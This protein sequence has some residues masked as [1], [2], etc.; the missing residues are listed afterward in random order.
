MAKRPRRTAKIGNNR[1]TG[2]LA[3]I[4]IVAGP[5]A[6]MALVT[7]RGGTKVYIPAPKSLTDDHWLVR[8]IGREVAEK[9][10]QY[11]FTPNFDHVK[12]RGK[13]F[14]EHKGR[15]VEI[16]LPSGFVLKQLA[17]R[18]RV[19]DMAI[20]GKT[21]AKIALTL[22]VTERCVRYLKKSIREAG[23]LKC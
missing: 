16:E 7:T 15:G 19:R 20:A 18:N 14:L 9:L 10:C 23:E 11:F 17:R 3:E 12:G 13:R 6:A 21:N 5:D 22:G 1:V 2:V 4:A 8:L